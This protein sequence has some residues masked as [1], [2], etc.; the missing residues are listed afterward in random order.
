MQTAIAYLLRKI[1]EKTTIAGIVSGVIQYLQFPLSATLIEWIVQAVWAVV[2]ILLV[3]V[4][5]KKSTV[6]AG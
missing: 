3:L 2:N 6:T 4:N 1:S 5:E